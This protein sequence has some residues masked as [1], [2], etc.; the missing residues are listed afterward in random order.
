MARLKHLP[1]S[2]NQ[3][4]GSGSFTQSFEFFN[5]WFLMNPEQKRL[6]FLNQSFGRCNICQ[7]HKLFNKAMRI[8]AISECDR[9]D[10]SLIRKLNAALR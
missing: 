8:E 4:R 10:F 9:G 5:A 1:F 3:A 6:F 7:H 2:Q